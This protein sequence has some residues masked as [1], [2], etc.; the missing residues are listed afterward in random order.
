[1]REQFG[2]GSAEPYDDEFWAFHDTGDWDGFAA[3]VLRRFSPRSVVDIGCGQGLALAAL[4]RAQPSLTRLGFDSS[5]AAVR[6]ARARGVNVD[7]LDLVAAPASHLQSVRTRVA[8]ADLAICLEVAEHLPPWR[9][10]TLLDLLTAAPRVIFSA[11]TPNQGGHRH[12]NERPACY[13]IDRFAECGFRLDAADSRFRADVRGLAL[14]SWYA[15]NVH[16]FERID[17][18]A[19]S[20]VEVT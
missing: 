1:V 16:V 2:S 19:S 12:L 20:A 8:A 7:H 18:P 17:R 5:S 4:G 13:W 14:P 9:A 15:N 11:A 3:A 10:G 6:R